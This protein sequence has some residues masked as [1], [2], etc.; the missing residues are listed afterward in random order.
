MTQ[1]VTM[2]GELDGGGWK[3]HGG[4]T[5]RDGCIYGYA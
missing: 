4:V 3:W 2:L 5:G 1:E